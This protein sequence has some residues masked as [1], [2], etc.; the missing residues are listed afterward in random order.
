MGLSSSTREIYINKYVQNILD[1]YENPANIWAKYEIECEGW[2]EDWEDQF[3][4]MKVRVTDCTPY[5]IDIEVKDEGKCYGY[6]LRLTLNEGL[7]LYPLGPEAPK[8]RFYSNLQD[9]FLSPY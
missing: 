7:V 8:T 4:G 3:P 1:F 5:H 6:I 9:Y 2:E